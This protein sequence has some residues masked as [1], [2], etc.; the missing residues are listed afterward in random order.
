MISITDSFLILASLR[1]PQACGFWMIRQSFKESK[2]TS[3][4]LSIS[5]Q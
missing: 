3:S 2:R 4:D 1:A 5:T